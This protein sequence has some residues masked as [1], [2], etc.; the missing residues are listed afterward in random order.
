MKIQ[1]KRLLLN[2]KYQKILKV[3]INKIKKFKGKIN[4]KYEML[5]KNYFYNDKKNYS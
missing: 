4:L 1:N 2:E 3:I 5:L